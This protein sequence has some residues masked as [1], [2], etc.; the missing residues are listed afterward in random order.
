MS[1]VAKYA[2]SN[3]LMRKV[4]AAAVNAE[5]ERIESARDGKLLPSDLVEAARD[6]SSALHALFDWND[7]EAA[8]RWRLHQASQIIRDL[9]IVY[10]NKEPQRIRVNVT[11][12]AGRAYV[13]IRLLTAGDALRALKLRMREEVRALQR[14]YADVLGQI[15]DAR[16]A[17]TRLEEALADDEELDDDATD[18]AQ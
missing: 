14:R 3:P 11:T 4:D 16:E 7:S 18:A 8:N 12:D 1:A 2:W 9:R 5:L 10:E 17:A 13:P 15:A 6:P